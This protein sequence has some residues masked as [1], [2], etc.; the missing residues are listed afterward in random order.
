[1]KVIELKDCP[2]RGGRWYQCDIGVGVIVTTDI[3]DG[4]GWLHVSVSR[5]DRIP[6]RR[7]MAAVKE[8]F[9]GD[10]RDAVEYWPRAAEY[11]NDHP[12]VLHLWARADG[13]RILPDMRTHDDVVGRLSI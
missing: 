4:N 9:I 13:Q 3:R 10:D 5:S 7:D 2:V 11:V 1:M 8:H 6:S 12:F